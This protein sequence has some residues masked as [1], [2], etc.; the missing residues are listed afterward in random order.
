MQVYAVGGAIR[1]E[2]LGKPSQDRDYVVVGATP[3]AMEAA[4]YKP[5]GKDFPV[6]LHPRTKEEYALARTERKTAMGY[7]GFA[8]YCEP[9]VSLEDD[10]VRRDLTINA[11]A[12]AVDADGNL[13]GPVI[14][15]HGGQRDLAAR[16]FRHVSDAF[17]EDP[18]RILRVARFAARFHE[19]TVAPETVALMRRMVDAGEVDALV[20]ERVWQELARG[21]MEARPS[22]MFEVLRECGALARLLPELD[23]L[24]GVPQ[25]ADYHPEVDTGV[26]VMMVIDCA[27]AMGTPL[28]VR[29]A[30]LVHDL[31]K[32]TTPEDVLPRHLGHEGRSVELLEEVCKRLRVPN[33]CR[34]LAVVV[35]REHGNIHRC[36]EFGAA[37]VTR[38]LE[39]C[40]ALRKPARFADALLACEADKRGRK[41]F[42]S[43]TY[44]QRRWLLAALEAAAGVDAGAIAKAAA[45]DVSQ[46]RERVH[47]AR[48]QAVA[49]RLDQLAD[50]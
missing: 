16:Q 7:K 23:R 49:A 30:A 11:M 38:L 48:V 32:G 44:P 17:A 46:I 20:S 33:D 10:L 37:A 4:G 35:A 43:D 39:R 50:H 15:P 42:E 18:V 29:F 36:L 41:G 27:A 21:L 47:A 12:R 9:D 3:A 28:A 8:F 24:W 2:L 26:H 13:V 45:D 22:R 31:G 40:D 14:D 5:V 1:D 6:F 19:F 34:D 25:R